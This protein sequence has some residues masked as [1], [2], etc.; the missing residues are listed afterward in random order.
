MSCT[1]KLLK[2]FAS[3]SHSRSRPSKFKRAPISSIRAS[4]FSRCD[5]LQT[6]FTDELRK[7]FIGCV[8]NLSLVI[9]EEAV[10]PI[11]VF[12]CMSSIKGRFDWARRARLHEE[13][14]TLLKTALD[15]HVLPALK[16]YFGHNDC[17]EYTDNDY[18][19]LW[20]TPDPFANDN[21]PNSHWQHFSWAVTFNRIFTE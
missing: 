10:S 14:P 16:K 1:S 20:D 8:K 7:N 15:E 18:R 13:D 11:E 17:V 12:E 6:A 9:V 3:R 21:D 5:N 4:L 2:P 19:A